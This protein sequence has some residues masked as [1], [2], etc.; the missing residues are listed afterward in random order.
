MGGGS[1]N[2]SEERRDERVT[3][4]LFAD[5]SISADLTFQVDI[6]AQEALPLFVCIATDA[7]NQ[8]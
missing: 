2:W 7:G 4:F 6:K 5:I 8:T 3:A 1:S